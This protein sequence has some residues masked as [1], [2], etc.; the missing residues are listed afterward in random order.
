MS[1]SAKICGLTDAASVE[2][3]VE[4]GARFV[5]L[6]FFPPS[7]RSLAPPRA[8]ALAAHVPSHVSKVG[9]FVDPADSLLDEVFAEVRLD[10]VQ[11]HGAESPERATAIRART[12]AGIIKAIKV[13]E[14]GDVAQA[15]AYG[16]A[17]DWILYDAKAP[18]GASR[19]GG[20]AQAFD[21]TI[22]A[23]GRAA[24]AG[25]PWLLSGG[26]D[27]DNVAQA[28]KITGARAVDVS[29]GVEKAPGQKDPALVRAFLEA[30]ARL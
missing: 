9:V 5:G 2:A 12:G 13:A 24:A 15:Q 8:G 7:P 26:L 10:F 4:G 18:K 17:A 30:V 25:L 19:P 27:I 21:W 11:L 1:V 14:A 29:S 22:L 16:Q 20:N 23:D 28:V 6:V 3:A